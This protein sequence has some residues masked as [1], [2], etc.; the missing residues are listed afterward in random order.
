M[1]LAT[2]KDGSR[3]GQL[4]VVS[5]DLA[6]A[7]YA[8]GIADR[9]QQALDDWGFMSPQLEDLYDRLNQGRARH[10]FPFDPAQCMAPLPRPAQ[11]VVASASNDED[12]SAEARP[13]LWR[14]AS[15]HLLGPR[16]DIVLAPGAVDTEMIVGKP[17]SGDYCPLGR[18]GQ[19]EEIAR[20]VHFL[21]ADGSSY[22]TGQVWGVN[23]GLDM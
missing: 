6:L 15:D 21:A 22:I 7:H 20:V 9:L 14:G 16:D 3:D 1:K 13:V 4:V 12:G 8:T 19:P 17:Y 10:P 2:L 23:G 18:L 5:R 11:W